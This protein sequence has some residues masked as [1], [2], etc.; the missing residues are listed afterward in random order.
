MPKSR[1][2]AAG[3]SEDAKHLLAGA[4]FIKDACDLDLLVFLQR[5]PRTLLTSEKLAAF[6]GYDMQQVAKALD[7]FVDAGI[8]ERIQSSTHGARM[9]LLSLNGPQGG[10]LKPLL[11]LASTREGRR[12]LL[13][14][15][16]AG[17]PRT[18]RARIKPGAAQDLRLIKSA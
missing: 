10:G 18:N 1:I 5:H 9:Y 6:V 8:L 3:Q 16:H 12:N 11:D 17:R 2:G 13:E 15:L 14:A 7:V 4:P